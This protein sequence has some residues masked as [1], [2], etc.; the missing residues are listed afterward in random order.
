MT[1]LLS[2]HLTIWKAWKREHAVFVLACCWCGIS[3]HRAEM[4]SA[5]IGIRKYEGRTQMHAH[6][7][8]KPRALKGQT[9]ILCI[10]SI[11]AAILRVLHVIPF[12]LLKRRDVDIRALALA[13]ASSLAPSKLMKVVHRNLTLSRSLASLIPLFRH[14]RFGSRHQSIRGSSERQRWP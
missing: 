10:A 12:R 13:P 1:F 6:G 3:Q 5:I 2:L 11:S 9:S 14:C 7:P 4:A 8:T